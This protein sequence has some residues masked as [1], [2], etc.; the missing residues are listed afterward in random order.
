MANSVVDSTAVGSLLGV[1]KPWKIPIGCTA[2]PQLKETSL[3]VL[4]DTPFRLKSGNTKRGFLLFR[5]P[6]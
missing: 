4:F 2:M 3:K 5:M 1:D 6:H